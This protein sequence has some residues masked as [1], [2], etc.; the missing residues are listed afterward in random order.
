MRARARRP[1]LPVFVLGL[2][3]LA[4]VARPLEMPAQTQGPTHEPAQAGPVLRIVVISDINGSYGTVGYSTEVRFA[5]RRI[6]ALEPDLVLG[7]GDLIAG[8]QISPLLERHNLE[9]MWEAFR[10][11]VFEPLQAAGIPFAPAPGNHDAS[12]SPGFELEREVFREQWE[13]LGFPA[14]EGNRVAEGVETTDAG[15]YPFRYAFRLQDVLFVVLD[16]TTVGPLSAAQ[17]AWLDEVLAQ[18][19]DARARVVAA[20]LPIHPLTRGRERETLGDKNLEELLQRRGVDL[21]LS[22]HHHGFYPAFRAGFLQVSQ[23]CL[24]SGPRRLIGES[25]RTPKS[26]TLIEIAPDGGIR[27]E[28]YAGPEFDTRIDTA[29]L[30]PELRYDGIVLRRADLAGAAVR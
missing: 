30:P 17:R 24:G 11:D 23:G 22:G 2:S 27:V 19:S 28:A 14:G 26:F 12:A 9:A 18:G 3:L 13:S 8:Q 7:V 25:D 15:D 16:A 5:I 4:L 29:S 10:T 1:V 6:V 20:H 21:F